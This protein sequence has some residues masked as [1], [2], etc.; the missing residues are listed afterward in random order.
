[1]IFCLS[2][3]H[4]CWASCFRLLTWLILGRQSQ[5]SSSSKVK[6]IRWHLLSSIRAKFSLSSN[7]SRTFLFR[8]AQ[9]ILRARDHLIKVK[10]ILNTKIIV[11][12]ALHSWC[13]ISLR[14]RLKYIQF[15]LNSN[16]KPS[17]TIVCHS[18]AIEKIWLF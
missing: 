17:Y 9:I 13:T 10:V 4:T 15:V 2:F 3:Y 8:C 7:T 14:N 12:S 1:M 18:F 11:I 16:N 6:P 5:I